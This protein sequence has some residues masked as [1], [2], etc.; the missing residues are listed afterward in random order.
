MRSSLR[1]LFGIAL[2]GR[3]TGLALH[4]SFQTTLP[5]SRGDTNSWQVRRTRGARAPA[6]L[7][8]VHRGKAAHVNRRV[9]REITRYRRE[10]F[11]KLRLTPNISRYGSLL[12]RM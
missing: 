9:L 3:R 5:R 11:A 12:F 2:L 8:T 10:L 4:S 1:S 7:S 6:L